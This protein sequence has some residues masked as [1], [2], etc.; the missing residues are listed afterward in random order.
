MFSSAICSVRVWKRDSFCCVFKAH[1]KQMV[2]GRSGCV[3]VGL[4]WNYISLP[5]K[6]LCAGA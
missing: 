4:L 3:G 5:H 2:V 6:K 1:S